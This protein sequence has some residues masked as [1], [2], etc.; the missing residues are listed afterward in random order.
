MIDME[1]QVLRDGG[2]GSQNRRVGMSWPTQEAVILGRRMGQC[3][4][5]E[6]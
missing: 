4:G 2:E 3:A 1:N 5:M 6:T